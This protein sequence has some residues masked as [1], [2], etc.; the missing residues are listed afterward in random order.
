MS[1]LKKLAGALKELVEVLN[2]TS[3]VHNRRKKEEKKKWHPLFHFRDHKVKI[4]K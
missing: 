4:R 3:P 2:S 1:H